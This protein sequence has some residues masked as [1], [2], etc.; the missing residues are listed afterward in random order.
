VVATI[1][2][3]FLKK[4]EK[5]KKALETTNIKTGGNGGNPTTLTLVQYLNRSHIS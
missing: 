2:I 1:A 4:E 3:S 5:R